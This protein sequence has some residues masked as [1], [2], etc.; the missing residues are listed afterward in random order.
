MLLSNIRLADIFHE[1]SLFYKYQG[2]K[3]RFRSLSYERAAKVIENN[4]EDIYLLI[5]KNKKIKGIGKSIA[6]K[7]IE[8]NNTGSIKKLEELKSICPLELIDL[9][10][11]RGFGPVALKILHEQL[12]INT[13]EQLKALLESDKLKS[14]K[15]L[16]IKKIE[17]IKEGLKLYQLFENRMLLWDALKITESVINWVKKC[18]WV[19]Q[20]ECAGSLRRQKETIGD[21]DL[22][23]SCNP[24]NVLEVANHL[25]DLQFVSSVISKGSERISII[26]KEWNKQIDF[27]LVPEEEWG[28]ALQHF[29]G[30]KE[31]NIALRTIAQKKNLK[32]SEHGILNLKSNQLDKFKSEI[33]LYNYLGYEFIPPEI[34]ENKGELELSENHKLP[35]LITLSDLKG[36]L[37]VHSLWS[38]GRNS[39]SE[40]VEFVRK[41]FNY[42]YIAITDHSKSSKI[43][44]GITEKQLEKQIKEIKLINKMLGIQFVKTGIEVDILSDG[45]LDFSDELLSQLDWVTASIHSGFK[46]D[47]TERII[48]ACNNKLVDCIGHPS[49]RLIGIRNPYKINFNEII[50]VA[51]QTGTALEI[52]AQP[53]RMDLNEE[54]ARV[55]KEYKVPLVISTDAH[56]NHEFDFMKLGIAIARRSWCEKKDILNTFSW[57]QIIAWKLRRVGEKKRK[58]ETIN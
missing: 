12:G 39:I 5:S 58:M 28:S 41:H 3:D 56:A 57:E 25:T 20:V 52:N 47:N 30:S 46:N 26:Y 31:H 29:T 7:I 33:E 37:H 32:L 40:M 44:R 36:D 8:F 53:N 14:I 18:K 43:A 1:M 49:G 54:F 55:A 10:N 2:N 34:R 11:V 4:E 17:I 19:N 27:L 22:V 24:K 15:G 45:K 50:H 9:L 35:N 48:A 42:E 13:K 16:G 23:V 38:D 6:E 51:K 21:I